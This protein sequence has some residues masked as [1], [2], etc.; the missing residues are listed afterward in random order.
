MGHPRCVR[1]RA[2]LRKPLTGL[3]VSPDDAEA[4]RYGEAVSDLQSDVAIADGAITG[5]LAY[6]TGY[7]GFSG[8]PDEQEGNYLALKLSA[9]PHDKVKVSIGDRGP[10][11]VTADGYIVARLTADDLSETLDVTVE[12]GPDSATLNLDISGLT[13][14]E[15]EE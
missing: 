2:C 6:V 3:T 11:D 1:V 5:T 12:N 4:E 9:E 10:V 15:E 8:D 13:L 7:T 14:S